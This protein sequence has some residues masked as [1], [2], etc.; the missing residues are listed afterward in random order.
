MIKSESSGRHYY[1][2]TSDLKD[3][4]KNH[5]SSQNRFTRGKGPWILIGFVPCGSKSEAMNIEQKLK[6]MRNPSRAIKWI[7][8]HGS[9][10]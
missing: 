9:V 1:G 10:Q 5:N 8:K 3:R 4:M 6:K 7:Q 2:H